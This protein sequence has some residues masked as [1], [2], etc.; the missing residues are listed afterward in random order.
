[1]WSLTTSSHTLV[2]CEDEC[3]I[4][5]RNSGKKRVKFYTTRYDAE[6]VILNGLNS[7]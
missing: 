6:N 4:P 7:I 5:T 3:Y 2:A 1:M